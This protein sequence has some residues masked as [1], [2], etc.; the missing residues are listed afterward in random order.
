MAKLQNPLLSG[1]YPD[2]SIC[3]VEDDYYM[4]TSSFSYYPGVPIFHSRDL[5][6]WEQIGHVLDRP[7]QLPLS[8]QNISHGI[9]AP[10][11]RHNNGMF[12]MITT[13]M[14]NRKNFIVT[15]TNPKGPWSDPHW[16][17]GADGIDPSLF[18][19]KDGKVYY[20]G[21]TRASMDS[22]Q[23]IYLREIDLNTFAFVG[24]RTLVWGGA[25]IDCASPEAP[26]IYKKDGWYYLMISEGG[27][28]HFHAVTIA[29][30]E[31]VRGPYVG[32]K[33][34]PILTHRHLGINYPIC[35]V[36]HA[37]MVE[38]QDGSWLMVLLASRIYGGYH[39][40]LGRE[41]FA[42]NVV[43]EDGWPV[44]NPGVGKV[45][46][47][48]D[49]PNLEECTYPAEPI[50]DNFDTENLNHC[51]NY[52][53]TPKP[54][55]SK[56]ENSHLYLKKTVAPIF[57]RKRDGEK[58]SFFAELT[59]DALSFLGRRQ[60]HMSFTSSAYMDKVSLNEGESAGVIVLQNG[61]C[62]VRLEAAVIDGESI[63]RVVKGITYTEGNI[64]KGNA[65]MHCEEEMLGETPWDGNQIEF[66]IT[67][68]EQDFSF[69]VKQEEKETI[70]YEHLH[71]GFM[72]SESAGGFV[73]AYIGMFTS[74]NGNESDEYIGFDWFTYKGE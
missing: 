3:R 20:T 2:P 49:I 51:W 55:L 43:W 50:K 7:E 31:N 40:N 39:K 45:E 72:G 1:F 71:G 64:F 29:R 48:C 28:E 18:W 52:L 73:G 56:L 24:E 38:C 37:D 9:F 5:A 19:D 11:I 67:A 61:Y 41:T 30:S 66:I 68:K 74:G 13:N 65:I 36:G 25:L 14:S 47:S 60:Q 8:Y 16:I 46:W 4:V 69:K 58:I 53:G 59:P 44:V 63:I 15:A 17:E 12:Y 70:V 23:M 33:G 32:F 57:P 6:H 21:T 54:N 34:N 35:N 42:A 26:H 22:K 10:T 62:H 27:T